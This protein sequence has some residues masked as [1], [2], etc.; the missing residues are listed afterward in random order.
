MVTQYYFYVSNMDY[1]KEK[2]KRKN[3]NQSSFSVN[4]KWYAFYTFSRT[5]KKVYERLTQQNFHAFLPL[6]TVQRQWSDRI[7]SVTI[8]LIHSYIFVKTTE[9]KLPELLKISG[10][11][12]VLKYLG[13]PAIIKEP[14]IENL[15]IV[16]ESGL[17]F[18]NLS[19]NALQEGETVEVVRGPLSGIVGRYINK[20]GKHRVI[21]SVDALQMSIE[22]TLPL[23]AVSKLSA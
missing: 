2:E 17:P 6:I 10:I 20:A 13:K 22:V 7:K 18:K 1:C 16:A 3:M 8:P 21:I 19:H 9:K 14:E 4:E 12:T 11:T 23:A 15:K 5:E